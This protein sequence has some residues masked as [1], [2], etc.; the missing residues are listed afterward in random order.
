AIRRHGGRNEIMV[1]GIG[2]A[3]GGPVKTGTDAFLTGAAGQRVIAKLD[4][5]GLRRLKSDTGA[6]VATVT[7]DDA[8]VQWI[9][10]RPQT[11]L[12]QK[13]MDSEAR[14]NDVGW[15]FTIPIAV[16]SALWFRRGWTIQWASVLVLWLMMESQGGASA[17]EWRFADIWLTPDQQGR[18]A[19]DR[20]E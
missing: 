8:D 1:L 19:F 7:A 20:G 4:I 18:I 13:E 14:W 17:A 16:F 12:Q 6:Q 2:T 9:V 5:D 11:H 10:R 15:W 3:A